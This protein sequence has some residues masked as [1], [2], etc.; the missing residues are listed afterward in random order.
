MEHKHYVKASNTG[1]GDNFGQSVVLSADGSTLAVGAY[2]EDSKALGVEGDQGDNS[3]MD[4]GAV[5][6]FY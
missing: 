2:A 5:Y 6:L 4:A 3:A 1:A